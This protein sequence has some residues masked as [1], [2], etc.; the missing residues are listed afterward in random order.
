MSPA[1]DPEV[2]SGDKA[3]EAIPD[4]DSDTVPAASCDVAPDWLSPDVLTD[5]FPEDGSVGEPEAER[6]FPFKELN[7]LVLT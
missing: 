3:P 5:E 4:E 2:A 1:F 7:P 6:D